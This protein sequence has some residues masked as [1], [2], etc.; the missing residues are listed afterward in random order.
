MLMF[1]EASPLGGKSGWFPVI[2]ISEPGVSAWTH[3]PDGTKTEHVGFTISTEECGYGVYLDSTVEVVPN[4]ERIAEIRELAIQYQGTL[5][6][7][8][9]PRKR[10]A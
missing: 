5:T 3:N 6:Q 10:A 9:L 1:V 2:S 8:G 4:K 7:K